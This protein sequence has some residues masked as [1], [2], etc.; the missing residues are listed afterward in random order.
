MFTEIIVEAV[1][2]GSCYTDCVNVREQ[3]VAREGLV[4]QICKL[5]G[6]LELQ[7]K[8]GVVIGEPLSVNEY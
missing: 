4:E 3:R 6:V 5:L 7:L 2:E 8:G 1:I